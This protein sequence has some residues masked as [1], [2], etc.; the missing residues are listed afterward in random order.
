V[1]KLKILYVV[2]R[3]GERVVGGSES[4]CRGF[5]EK[6]VG[7]GHHVEVL[8]SCAHSY[9]DWADEY[10]AGETSLNDVKIHRLPVVRRRSDSE[11][12]PVHDHLMRNPYSS[13]RSEQLRWARLMGPELR[14]QREWLMRNEA[15]FDVAIFMTYLYATTTFGLPVLAGRIPTV[16]Q[17]TAH[18]EPPAYVPL[19][20]SLFRLP[21]GFLFFTE[22]EREIVKAIYGINPL[23]R[24]VGIG[25][26]QIESPGQPENV[27]ADFGLGGSPYVVY[28]GRL[29]ASKGVGELLRFFRSYRERHDG[30]LKLVLVG[31]GELEIPDDVDIVKTGFVDEQTKRDVIAGATAL[32]QPSY[33]ESF[34]IVVCEAW[35]Q[36]R[37]ALVQG[38][39]SVLRGQA[40][41]SGGAIP[42]EGF[43]EFEASLQ[44][45]LSDP[46]LATNLGQSGRDYVRGLYTWDSVIDGVEQTIS[47]SVER[48]GQRRYVQA[49]SAKSAWP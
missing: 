26:D 36:G 46:E 39:C 21:D 29:D 44:L 34:S 27:R 38:R 41:R 6:L 22:E 8:T 30:L 17:P 4:A 13:P 18:D 1:H 12:G 45:L 40:L 14:G 24:V 5:A 42:Y 35:L 20:Q 19:Y 33:F 16:L 31:D 23:G 37:P 2:Q 25:L 9:V 28:V 7:R 15:R 49:T 48:F 3:Y 32:I 43:A 11:F 10:P 47:E